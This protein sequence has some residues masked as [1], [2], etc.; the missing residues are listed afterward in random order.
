MC[1]KKDTHLVNNQLKITVFGNATG[2]NIN[3]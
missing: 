1:M 3:F 2:G